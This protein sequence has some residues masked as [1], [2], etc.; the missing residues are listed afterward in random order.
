MLEKAGP[1]IRAVSFSLLAVF[2]NLY[3]RRNRI[4]PTLKVDRRGG[5]G[6]FG[7]GGP[8]GFLRAPFPL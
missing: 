5:P 7:V 8:R 3:L 4:Y 1:A 2:K 6:F